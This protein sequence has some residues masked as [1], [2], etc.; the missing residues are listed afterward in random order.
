MKSVADDCSADGQAEL[1]FELPTFEE[2]LAAVAARRAIE[3]KEAALRAQ[4]PLSAEEALSDKKHAQ[5]ADCIE[6]I[7]RAGFGVSSAISDDPTYP[8]P[9]IE[10]WECDDK[11]F[12]AALTAAGALAQ[13]L[14]FK[15]VSDTTL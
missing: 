12:E 14:R 7:A 11:R 5:A 13:G 6:A 8:F 2:S 9:L 3:A 4:Q 15:Q 1:R 10:I